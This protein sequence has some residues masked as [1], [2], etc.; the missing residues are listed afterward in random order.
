VQKSREKETIIECCVLAYIIYVNTIFDSLQ[1][2]DVVCDSG[3][4]GGE[5]NTPSP[6]LPRPVLRSLLQWRLFGI[7]CRDDKYITNP[8]VSF[9]GQVSCY[10]CCKEAGYN[11]IIIPESKCDIIAT[12]FPQLDVC[13]C[14]AN[15]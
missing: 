9:P 8:I 11:T 14:R 1:V 10:I 3:T 12:C 2:A 5:N 7:L 6:K 4:H 13:D 15:F